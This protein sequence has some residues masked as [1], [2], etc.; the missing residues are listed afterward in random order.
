L[1]AALDP[2]LRHG[3]DGLRYAQTRRNGAMHLHVGA[4]TL[5]ARYFEFDGAQVA[6]CLYAQPERW[7]AA[8]Q[9]RRF[10]VRR[11]GNALRLEADA[12]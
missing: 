3:Y 11:E 5:V 10:T 2:L 1:A 6:E 4:E 9:E 7:R 12:P 8:V